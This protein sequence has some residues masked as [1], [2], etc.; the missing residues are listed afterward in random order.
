MKQSK[1][2]VEY[3]K[4]I[5]KDVLDVLKGISEMPIFEDICL[6]LRREDIHNS[7]D[8]E[9]VNEYDEALKDAYVGY[10]TTLLQHKFDIF[11]VTT[12]L[13]FYDSHNMLVDND[14]LQTIIELKHT[15]SQLETAI[16]LV[17]SKDDVMQETMYDALTKVGYYDEDSDI[18]IEFDSS[19]DSESDIIHT[20][21]NVNTDIVRSTF[22]MYDYRYN[23]NKTINENI[24]LFAKW[25]L[26]NDEE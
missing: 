7:I 24:E 21:S 20:L 4:H 16:A 15:I 1:I 26:D 3:Y 17:T 12:N 10:I 14:A 13:A 19:I 8:D 23:Y 25:F 2:L 9:C 11:I 18:L 6:H 5:D 22:N